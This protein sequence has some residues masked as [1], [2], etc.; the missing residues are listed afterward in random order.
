ML[1]RPNNI[2]KSYQPK[3]QQWKEWCA[4]QDFNNGEIF[5]DEKLCFGHSTYVATRENKYKRNREGAPTSLG[6]ESILGYVRA[7]GD[8]YSQQKALG[9]N[10]H[11]LAIGPLGTRTS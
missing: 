9:V 10:T 5:T 2:T 7:V 8:I 3:Q 6:R 11:G 4:S 1:S